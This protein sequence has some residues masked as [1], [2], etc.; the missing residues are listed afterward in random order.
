M[1]KNIERLSQDVAR[2]MMKERAEVRRSSV[3]EVNSHTEGLQ[4]TILECQA[5]LDAERHRRLEIEEKL[6]EL[7]VQGQDRTREMQGLMSQLTELRGVYGS[8]K[9]EVLG[10]L[11]DLH[12]RLNKSSA[13][14]SLAD[15]LA[16]LREDCRE[17]LQR[18]VR[19]RTEHDRALEQ[20]L[21][22]LREGLETH[23]HNMQ[24]HGAGHLAHSPAKE[25]ERGQA[26]TE[27]SDVR[28][29][30]ARGSGGVPV[31][32]ARTR[33]DPGPLQE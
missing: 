5:A 9:E 32:P 21:E 14:G 33:G 17:A 4:R 22:Q 31:L 15:D 26:P 25:L 13:G 19:L 12:G 23:T 29:A 16:K 18:E 6:R 8:M 28:G 10:T 20:A 7:H 3:S 2:E 30:S 24:P 11:E 1:S 27:G